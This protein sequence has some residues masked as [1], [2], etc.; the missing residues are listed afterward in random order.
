MTETKTV[1]VVIE[2]RVQGVWFRGWAVEQAA[3]RG[4]SGWIRN[5]ADGSVEALISGPA[6]P[7]EAMVAA[8]RIGP[9][10]AAVS[11]LSLWPAAPPDGPGFHSRP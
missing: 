7:V 4:L 6:D 2:G 9:P 3:A 11:R 10:A 1:R 5:R 8:C